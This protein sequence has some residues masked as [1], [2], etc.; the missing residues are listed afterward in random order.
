[1]VNVSPYSR[2]EPAY[3]WI[4][5]AVG[6]CAQASAAAFVVGLASIAPALRAEYHLS[7]TELGVM[8]GAPTLGLVVTL[9]LWGHASDRYGE[10]FVM[11]VGLTL[12]AAL[13]AVVPMLP[14]LGLVLLAL[15]G[16]GAAVAGINAAS[17][18]VVMLWF[19]SGARG[20]AMAIRQCAL[21]LGAAFA[22]MTLPTIAAAGGTRAAFWALSGFAATA[23]A[24]VA[25]WVRGPHQATAAQTGRPTGRFTVRPLELIRHR[26]LLWLC[27]VA[28]LL[29][30][31]Q[32]AM[33]G[34]AIELLG[35]HA[36]RSPARAAEALVC[37]HLAGA[38]LRLL[39]GWWSD[40][41][42]DGL[43]L[44]QQVA[45]GMVVAFTALTVLLTTHGQRLLVELVVVAVGALAVCWNG[46]AF[47]VAGEMAPP[48]RAGAFL[49]F[50]NTAIFG[51]AAVGAV[52]VGAVAD[53][54]GWIV[55][56][57]MLILP[58]LAAA[59]VLANTRVTAARRAGQAGDRYLA[60]VGVD[61][62]QEMEK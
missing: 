62:V 13:L 19:P 47:L 39:L 41:T 8:I 27:V 9:L 33:T 52:V 11:T 3:R 7:L 37:V 35:A 30:L 24:A 51:T 59:T 20:L 45:V 14:T 56:S 18:L 61:G 49:G 42:G 12:G 1:V 28:A 2:R 10:R 58:A 26:P 34:F 53:G 29:M 17:G 54:W 5:V 60:R 57:G 21:P 50:E 22:A 43:R 46:L 38:G 55:A 48:G 44:L 40:Q 31:P 25:V 6:T 36:G 15:A 16:A 32:V 4:I 23:A